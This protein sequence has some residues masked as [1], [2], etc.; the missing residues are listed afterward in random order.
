MVNI[1][2]QIGEDIFVQ[3]L[4]YIGKSEERQLAGTV[5]ESPTQDVV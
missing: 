4:K 2:A 1:Q 5:T 3:W